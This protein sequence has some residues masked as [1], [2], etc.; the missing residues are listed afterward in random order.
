MNCNDAAQPQL[1]YNVQV[2]IYYG[3]LL[4]ISF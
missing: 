4:M 1:K 3:F 2:D